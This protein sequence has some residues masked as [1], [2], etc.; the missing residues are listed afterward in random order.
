MGL[1]SIDPFIIATIVAGMNRARR[2]EVR[3]CGRNSRSYQ[4]KEELNN[5]I[6]CRLSMKDVSTTGLCVSH[7]PLSQT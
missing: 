6:D 5:D 3:S 7:D 2:E 4:E 1:F